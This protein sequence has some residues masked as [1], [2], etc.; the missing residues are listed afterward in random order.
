MQVTATRCRIHQRERRGASRATPWRLCHFGRSD[1]VWGFIGFMRG[2]RS[3]C[4]DFV[5]S[6]GV[7][8]HG[9]LVGKGLF[10]ENATV[11]RGPGGDPQR[12]S[13][14]FLKRTF[15]IPNPTYQVRIK[16]SRA[17]RRSLSKNHISQSRHSSTLVRLAPCCCRDLAPTLCDDLV[18]EGRVCIAL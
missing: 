10:G 18:F 5:E 4:H 7:K 13:L 12:V 9:D 6:L 11:R 15:Q 3:V 17:S 2:A 14:R 1:P 8:C 16:V